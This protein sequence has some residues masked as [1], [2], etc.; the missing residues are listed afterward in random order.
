MQRRRRWHLLP[1]CHRR[2]TC[3]YQRNDRSENRPSLHLAP[4][5]AVHYPPPP[6]SRVADRSVR[7][8][9]VSPGPKPP[10]RRSISSPPLP[11]LRACRASRAATITVIPSEQTGVEDRSSASAPLRSRHPLRP[12][13]RG[14]FICLERRV[15]CLERGRTRPAARGPAQSQPRVSG[16]ARFFVLTA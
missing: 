8:A 2:V 11:A 4:Q 1:R 15:T 10:R 5:L 3:F 14:R 12:F 9:R 16:G 7:L 6:S 13:G